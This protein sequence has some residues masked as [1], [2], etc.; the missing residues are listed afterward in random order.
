M[1]S[2][3]AADHEPYEFCT[4]D[5]SVQGRRLAVIAAQAHAE[6]TIAKGAM[7]TVVVATTIGEAQHYRVQLDGWDRPINLQPEVLRLL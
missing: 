5:Y 3:A 1:L 2:R 7:G 6:G 4:L